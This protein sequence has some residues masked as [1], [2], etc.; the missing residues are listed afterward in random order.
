M[1]K[2]D[3]SLPN[4]EEVPADSILTEPEFGFVYKNGQGNKRF[5][6]F[7]QIAR[8]CDGTL[9]L[10]RN[11]LNSKV[12][13]D[14]QGSKKLNPDDKERAERALEMI[15]EKMEYRDAMRRFEILF[16]IRRRENP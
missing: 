8:Y 7:S 5:L 9:M 3:Q 1:L 15:K 4:I 14:N 2:P 11:Q 13:L 12:M 16:A 10:I 6:R